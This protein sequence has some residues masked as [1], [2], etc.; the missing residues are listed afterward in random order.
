MHKTIHTEVAIIGAGTAGLYALREVR[1]ANKQFVMIDKGPL[2]T[3]CARVGCMPSKLALHAGAIRQQINTQAATP[4]ALPNLNQTWATLREQRDTFTDRAIKT[5]QAAAQN[6]LI[7]GAARFLDPVTIKITQDNITTLVHAEK[8]IIANGSRP[9]VPGWLEPV[10]EYTV[11]TDEIFELKELPSSIGILGLGAIGMEMGLA[12]S[13]LGVRVVGA[14]LSSAIAGIGDPLINQQAIQRFGKEME[15]WLGQ[16]TAV[17]L[18]EKGVLLQS[19]NRQIKVDLLLAAL[20][21]RPNLDALNLQEAGFPLNEKGIP[22]FN[23][24]TMQVEGLP[25]FLAGDCTSSKTL[26]HEASAEGSIAGFNAVQNHPVAFKRMVPLGIAFS[27]P[28]IF[29]AGASKAE[30]DKHNIITGLAEG[31]SNGRARI[32]SEADSLLHIYADAENGTL[33]GAAGMAPHAEHLAHL[34]AWAIQRGETAVSLLQMP[35][36]HPVLEEMVQS[37]LQDIVRQ[38]PHKP[39]WPFG[40][41]PVNHH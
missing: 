3:T 10:R 30:L 19:G 29:S 16:P 2:G 41:A 15:L 28:D 1:R 22:V 33:L 36:Y 20:G 13:R 31:G 32:L 39:A 26:M 18:A 24:H 21:R 9:A 6:Q 5:T 4:L 8:V 25:V 7:T 12:L 40:L 35:F 14:D 37:A 17:S 23:P 27:D 34:L 11:S 38:L